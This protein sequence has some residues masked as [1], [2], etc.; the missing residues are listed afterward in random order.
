MAAMEET[1][2]LNSQRDPPVRAPRSQLFANGR[3]AVMAVHIG[4]SGWSYA[5]WTNVLYPEGLPA[6]GRLDHYSRQFQTVELNAS[7]Y[8]CPPI[9]RSRVGSGACRT[10][11]WS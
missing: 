9:P 3:I 1:G 4:T 5:H 7:Y 11:S 6:E 10:G 2:L 8:R